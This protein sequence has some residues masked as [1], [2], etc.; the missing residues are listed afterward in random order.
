[1][2]ILCMCE[3]GNVRSVALAQHIKENGHEA[4]AIGSKYC[5]TETIRMLFN[6]CDKFI[7][8]RNYLPED[9]WHNPRDPEL[10]KEVAKIWSQY[11]EKLHYV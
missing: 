3:G 11:E 7:D 9:K 1:M 8:L 2:R 6:W 10:K 4:I 5:S